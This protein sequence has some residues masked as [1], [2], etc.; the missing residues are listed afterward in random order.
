MYLSTRTKVR[1]L[2]L[3]FNTLINSFGF[4]SIIMQVMKISEEEFYSKST[5]KI[6][7][8]LL[9]V[10]SIF[11][12]CIIMN[13]LSLIIFIIKGIFNISYWFSVS[14]NLINLIFMEFL[15]SIENDYENLDRVEVIRY[16]RGYFYCTLMYF[17]YLFI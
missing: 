10:Q 1:L 12:F 3:C 15:F 17:F 14:L 7:S 4:Y 9:F 2:A 11:G 6:F 13:V 16:F 8:K 5:T